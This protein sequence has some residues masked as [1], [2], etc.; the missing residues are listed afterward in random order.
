MRLVHPLSG[1]VPVRLVLLMAYQGVAVN[2]F[3]P[4][5]H[6][7]MNSLIVLFNHEAC[8]SLGVI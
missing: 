5:P 8:Q 1:W 7:R 6:I 2:L 3:M 4:T